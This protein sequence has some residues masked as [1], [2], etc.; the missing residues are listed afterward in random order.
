VNT[1]IGVQVGVVP[2]LTH[3]F[4]NLATGYAGPALDLVGVDQVNAFIIPGLTTASIVP[5]P[6]PCPR[7][8]GSRCRSKGAA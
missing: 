1:Q 8:A 2:G 7:V 4:I 5:I 3:P 6:F